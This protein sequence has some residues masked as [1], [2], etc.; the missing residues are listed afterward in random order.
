MWITNE[1]ETLV[2]KI[3]GAL[4]HLGLFIAFIGGVVIGASAKKRYEEKN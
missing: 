2:K 1:E 3:G 4:K